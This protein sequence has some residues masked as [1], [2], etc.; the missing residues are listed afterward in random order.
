M[1]N[2]GGFESNLKGTR[3]FITYLKYSEEKEK[4]FKHVRNIAVE[5]LFN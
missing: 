3:I 5:F 4:C 2:S 1:L